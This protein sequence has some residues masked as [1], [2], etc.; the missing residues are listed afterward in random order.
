[1][2]ALS[3]PD[4][5]DTKFILNAITVIISFAAVVY[6]VKFFKRISISGKQGV[7]WLWIFTSVLMVLLLNL[8]AVIIVANTGIL[9]IGFAKVSLVNV[10]TLEF[11]NTVGRTLIAISVTIGAY[12]LYQ[13]MKGKGDVKFVFTPV[14]PVPEPK[15]SSAPKYALK[16][17]YSYLA[18]KDPITETDGDAKIIADGLICSSMDLF[19]D[20]VTH[21][22]MGFIVTRNYPQ[23]IREKY[24][25]MK[26]P[27]MWLTRDQ[28]S[29][30]SISPADLAEL[31]H[32]VKDFIQ[33]AK[34]TVVLIDGLEY[35]IMHNSFEE[36]LELIQGLDDVVVQ[37]K[38]RL[39]V[40][41]DPQAVTPQQLHLLMTE[42][43][44]GQP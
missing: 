12:L 6:W 33:T 41:V 39:I 21:G 2:D 37:S 32:M 23:R 4:F 3:P 16:P 10:G 14:K 38:S 20:L 18:R 1:M 34:D 27:M 9:S 28:A 25:L 43:K 40:T 26:T 35:L 15:S 31:S 30:S 11:M 13:S 29:S 36:A 42:L 8:S 24:N 22:T 19:V 7:G 44:G 17:G 5:T